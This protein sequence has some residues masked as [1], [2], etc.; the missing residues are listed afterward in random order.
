MN[1]SQQVLKILKKNR[2]VALLTPSSIE[3]CLTA[4]EVFTRNGVILEIALRSEHALDGITV[5]LDKHPDALILAGTVMTAEQAEAVIKA[6]VAGVVSADYIPSVVEVCVRKD[7][8]CVP[9]GLTDVGKQLVQKA[10]LYGCSMED[11]KEKYPYQW[12]YKLFPAVAG[13]RK[14]YDLAKAW[15]GPYQD[16]TILYTGGI[17]SGNVAELSKADPQGIFCGSGLTKSINDPAVMQA[18]IE[19]WIAGVRPPPSE[20]KTAASLTKVVIKPNPEVVTFGEI[21]LRL[22]PPDQKRFLQARGYDAE[23]GG[24]EANVA[25]SLTNFG[26]NSRF[27]SALPENEIGQAAVN[28]LRQYGVDTSYIIR[29]GNR[30]GIYFLEQ[31]ASQR[32]SKVIY[33]RTG[34]A[35]SEIETGQVDWETV[36]KEADW[37]HWSGITPALSDSVSEVTLEALEVAKKLGITVSVDLNYRKKLWSQD[38]AQSIMKELIRFVDICIGNE[39]DAESYFGIKAERSDVA[40]GSLDATGYE[41]VARQLVDRF[42]LRKAIITLRESHSA[43]DNSWSAVLFN[44]NEAYQSRKYR[45]HLVDRVGG[46]DAF[47]AGLIYG[48]INGKSDKDALEFATAASCLKQTIHGDFN[49]V[50]VQEVEKLMEGNAGGRIQR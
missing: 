39:E 40:A 49:L 7:V 35:I 36:F 16:L 11:L 2:L 25:V 38:K 3:D 12:I 29:T 23:F 32:P 31:G 18:N 14:Y 8:M 44:G 45:I 50:T 20:K 27:V 26:L 13:S 42:G 17:T 33:D 30:I 24:S 10:A 5:I 9:G 6:G 46:G 34:S 37:F 28:A 1:K 15:R 48:F 43:S 22:S 21:M 4:Y 47:S 41:D 19:K